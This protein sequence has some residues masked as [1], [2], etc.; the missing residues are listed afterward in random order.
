MKRDRRRYRA[1][2]VGMI[3]VRPHRQ[4]PAVRFISLFLHIGIVFG[5]ASSARPQAVKLGEADAKKDSVT[6]NKDVAPI[7]FQCCGK[8]H[9]PGQ[10]APF[11]LLSYAEVKKR[12]K[13]IA[14]VVQ[15]RYMP[16]WLP[17][18][19]E[20][21][22][23]GDP[24]LTEEQIRVIVQ[25]EA[26]GSPE[27][28]A[29]NLP[30]LPQWAQG[31]QLGRPDLVVKSPQPY[32]LAAEGRDVYHNLVVPIPLTERKYIRGI[33]FQPDNRKVVHHAL[34]TVD[35][36]PV[37]RLRAAKEN[38]PGFDGMQLPE[39]A[40]MPDGYFLGWAPG[41]VQQPSL[42]GMA[43]V[44]QPG[45]DLTL[46]MHLHPSGK[47]E[48]VQPSVA[49]Y[50]TDEA[51]TN[52]PLRLNL[53][54]PCID[55]PAGSKD[56][57][58]EDS[59]TLPVEVTLLAIG[60][61]AHYLGKRLEGYAHLADGSKKELLLIKNWD[62]NWQTEFRYARP[63]TLPKEATLTMRWVYDNSAENPHNPNQPPK[64]VRYGPQTTDEMG[65]LWF[66]LLPR[67]TAE[68]RLLERDYDRHLARLL[69]DCNESLLAKNP[70]DAEAHTKAGRANFYFGDVSKA[71]DHF[72]AAIKAD[73][74]FDRAYFE[75]GSIYLRQQ[76]LAEAQE[77]FE[78][79]TRYNP[80]DYEAEGSLGIIFLRQRNMEQA[81]AH[82]RAALKINPSDKLAGGYLARLLD[83]KRR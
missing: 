69:L 36:T 53:E 59:Y 80:D 43:W 30:P 2:K 60:P 24:S 23:A 79:V 77:A 81:E 4:G 52:S 61:H 7:V 58:V 44:L 11:T 33:E 46:Q 20:V 32:K 5:T 18:R 27:G 71:T 6:F 9:S 26:E 31:W 65:E 37:C 34:V 29:A 39:T 47:I 51:P 14:E 83:A 12:A 78:N 57:F 54:A 66:Q 38:P 45:T 82:F 1:D 56:Y 16:P 75:L 8:C 22:F 10:A 15:K 49:L 55:I 25:W 48:M 40:Q 73:P 74:K 21:E 70:N 72:L 41:R 63:I 64:R 13:Q 62:F 68:R 76:K 50:F 3:C 17:E 28:A 42:A 19:G 35:P 67:N